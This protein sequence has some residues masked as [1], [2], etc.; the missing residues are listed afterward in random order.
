MSASLLTEAQSS[1]GRS[2]PEG[3]GRGSVPGAA[4]RCGLTLHRG[5]LGVPRA[6]SCCHHKALGRTW[7][8][9]QRLGP[10]PR[11]ACSGGR[12]PLRGPDLGRLVGGGAPSEVSEASWTPPRSA[13]RL[14]HPAKDRP[15]ARA[16][17]AAWTEG[18]GPGP[19]A[20]CWE[21]LEPRSAPERP[22]GTEEHAHR[23]ARCSS[24]S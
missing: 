3:R 16:Q 17:R 1:P 9:R 6:R 15:A 22:V 5:D 21:G 19:R 18:G 20:V 7:G 10:H 13:E 8:H 11:P 4:R 12:W 23:S 14:G 24:G 2:S